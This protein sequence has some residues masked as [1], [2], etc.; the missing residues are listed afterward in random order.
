MFISRGKKVIYLKRIAMGELQL[1]PDLTL[2]TYRE[3]REEEV[4][5]LQKGR[6][7]E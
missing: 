5:L 6:E 7:E 1:D 3:L 2:G 4:E